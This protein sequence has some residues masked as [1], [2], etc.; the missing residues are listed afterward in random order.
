MVPETSERNFTPSSTAL[1]GPL[2]TVPGSAVARKIVLV[3]LAT[4]RLNAFVAL[5][6]GLLESVTWAVKLKFPVA[7]GVPEIAPVPGASVNP[8]GKEPLAID[9]L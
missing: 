3:A 5:C 9:Q 1:S 2:S 6:G 8:G 7:V 4:V